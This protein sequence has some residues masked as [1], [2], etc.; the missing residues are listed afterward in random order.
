MVRF[1]SGWQR[2]YKGFTLIELLVV[3]AIIA[4]LIGLLLP[5]V[6]KVRAAAARTTC[7]NN[8]KNLGLAIHNY[9][10]ANAGN[11]PPEI[12]YYPPNPGSGWSTFHYLLLPYMEQQ[13]IYN[14]NIGQGQV[15]GTGIQG[16]AGAVKS[17]VC[18]AD[19]GSAPNGTCVYGVGGSWASSSYS[20]NYYMFGVGN[21]SINGQTSNNSRYNIGNIPDG[22]SMTVGVVERYG[23]FQNWGWSSASYF[24]G[25]NP[26][27]WQPHQAVYG[28]WGLNAPQIAP[29]Q[30]ANPV[31]NPTCPQ[32]G[33]P[34]S[35][36]CLLMDGSI[37]QVTSAISSTTWNYACQPDDGNI[38]GSDWNS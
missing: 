28:P 36:N 19:S 38:L 9:A 24:Y 35:M 32:A 4:I 16:A 8:M 37:K 31:A 20:S 34:G 15:W 10:S 30:N 26:W 23:S 2:K 17:Y 1:L 29:A 27:G 5:A 22:T 18:P 7:Q 25:G 3:I 14:A 13:A 11:L 33:H 21:N 6:Q 12:A